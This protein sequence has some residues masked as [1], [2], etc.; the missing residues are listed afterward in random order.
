MIAIMKLKPLVYIIGCLAWQ[1]SAHA[2]DAL[3]AYRLGE[4]GKAAELF[5]KQ[6]PE[7]GEGLYALA[8]MYAY[9][10]GIPRDVEKAISYY[11]QSAEKNYLPALQVMSRYELLMKHQPDQALIW[12]KKA[13]DLQD[14]NSMMYCAA[15]FIYGLGTNANEDIAKKYY[16][17]AAKLG[18]PL[19]Q[20]TLA[21]H[22]FESKVGKN[23]QLAWLWL[24]KAC[25]KNYA[26][27]MTY[28]AYL[29][30]KGEHIQADPKLAQ[31]FMNKVL[32]M[33][34]VPAL[35][36]KGKWALAQNQW[37]IAIKDFKEAADKGFY[38]AEIALAGLYMEDT[39][40]VMNKSIGFEWMMKAARHHIPYAQKQLV[41]FYTNGIGVEKN[42]NLAKKW[43]EYSKKSPHAK[44]AYKQRQAAYWLSAGKYKDFLHGDYALKGIWFDWQN[45]QA[46]QQNNLNST[47]RFLILGLHEIFKPNYNLVKPSQIPFVEY[48]DVIM[49]LK[50]PVAS[51]KE[52]MPHYGL[53]NKGNLSLD[54]F[55]QLDH[56]AQIGVPEAQFMLG[57]CYLN[58]IQTKKDISIAR[59]WFE[60][61]QAQD[62]LRAQYEL[63]IMDLES[64]DDETKKHGLKML[65][66]AAFKGN[67]HAEYTYGLLNE[68]GI[69]N[70]AGKDLLAVNID[71]AKNMFRLASLNNLGVAKFRLAEWLSREPL[72][73]IP[74][75]E[76]E[77]R[78][79]VIRSLYYEAV[80]NGIDEAKMPLAF[81]MA[82][83]KDPAKQEWALKIA[84]EYANKG[85]AEASLLA[86]LMIDRDIKNPNHAN[87]ALDWYADAKKHP[88]GGF[89]WASLSPNPDKVKAYLNKAADAGFSY[90]NLNLAVLAHQEHLSEVAD[91]QKA[92]AMNNFMASHLLANQLVLN[93][94]PQ[95]LKQ[96]RDIF[97]R[98]AEKGDIEAQAKLGYMYVH[99]LGGS[100]DTKLGNQWLVHAAE[101]H[102]VIAQFLLATMYHLGAF[103]ETANDEAAKYWFKQSAKA[104]PAAA[105]DLGF[106]YETVDKEYGLALQSYH[107]ALPKVKLGSYYNIGLIYQYGK[108][109][110]V[111]FAKAEDNFKLAVEAGSPKAMVALG[112]LFLFK[113]QSKEDDIQALKW[114]QEAA[115]EGQSDALYRIGLLYET[116]IGTDLNYSQ[117]RVFYAKAAKRGDLKAEKAL[118]RI[119]MY[120]LMSAG[121]RRRSIQDL[122]HMLAAHFRNRPSNNDTS[123]SVELRYL[124]VLDAWNRGQIKDAK[125]DI[126]KIVKDYPYYS[127]AKMMLMQ[128]DTPPSNQHSV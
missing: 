124:S 23:E 35:V 79:L 72:S 89:V 10:Y 82:S 103:G 24:N 42:D 29:L 26:P 13:A 61:A 69:K 94:K 98:L 118:E 28:K 126:L 93:G 84:K 123:L 34:Y 113:S 83:S 101:Q 112:D 64:L 45:H 17:G 108:G 78:Q 18:N 39:T 40:P 32:A 99:G 77:K 19:A 111:D 80:K 43:Q 37:D 46:L 62:E 125:E 127:P 50:G 73:T 100:L 21:K 76:R 68:V 22:F 97:Q 128:M 15:A 75:Q 96:S 55:N 57:Q 6:N 33:N 121:N 65:K 53:P 116:G 70:K 85:D 56:Q 1:Y 44:F 107:Q 5:A 90:A 48:L 20:L 104:Y 27:A 3:D 119:Q 38:P 9:G 71:D 58:G 2:D 31:A 36:L 47:P 115:S 114:Y 60:K 63:A 66:D 41:E 109:A 49:R 106:I 51:P 81:H 120:G 12:F 110:S 95:D 92:V 54:E 87:D 4:Y 8:E 102:H 16:I 74:V 117:A 59:A 14:V 52:L 91:L 11:T 67:P 30:N 25:D 88:I 86:G 122:G 7:S 105:V